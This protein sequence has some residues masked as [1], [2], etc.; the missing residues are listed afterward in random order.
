MR[1]S[2][3]DI[4]CFTSQLLWQAG[5]DTNCHRSLVS[6]LP[7]QT[8]PPS[9]SPT[10]PSR[11]QN[12]TVE[13]KRKEFTT[14]IKTSHQPNLHLGKA[15]FHFLWSKKVKPL[16]TE[17]RP[18]IYKSN[19]KKLFFYRALGA[20]VPL[21]LDSLTSTLKSDPLSKFSKINSWFFCLHLNIPFPVGLFII[22]AHFK[23]FARD[24]LLYCGTW[25][26]IY[27]EMMKTAVQL[28][29]QHEKFVFFSYTQINE[30]NCLVLKE[31]VPCL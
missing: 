10:L 6:P 12:G 1:I 3:V 15:Q 20:V 24:S 22:Y 5:S 16:A 19:Y 23:C 21:H 9:F 29:S 2:E 25:M 11:A 13:K 8:L 30:S 18:Y 26:L 14:V 4:V 28:E 7:S 31:W 17:D 27:R